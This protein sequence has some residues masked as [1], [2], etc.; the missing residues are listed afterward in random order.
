MRDRDGAAA[1]D[2]VL[3]GGVVHTFAG[4]GPAS[5][6]AVRGGRIVTVGGDAEVGDLV[7]ADTEVVDLAGRCVLPGIN[8]AHLHGLWLG[9]LWPDTL[10]GGGGLDR[11][12]PLV[13]TAEQR[14]AA[15]G[16]AGEICAALGIT[17]YTEPGL[18]PGED[19]GATG[20]FG[21]SALADYVALADGGRLRQRV[22]ALRLFGK[23]DGPSAC[24]DLL[25]GIATP[26][27]R[28]ADPRRFRVAGV[29]IFADGIPPMHSAWLHEPYCGGG[30]GGL[31]VEGRDDAERE[32]NL[33]AMIGAA[34]RA[35]LQVGVHVTGDRA[36]DVVVDAL[37]SSGRVAGRHYL[38][39]GDLVAPETLRRMSAAG[40]GLT[41]QP[42]IA[43]V[44][45]DMMRSAVGPRVTEA[46]PLRAMLDAG[47]PLTIS[48][49]A[50]VVDPDWRRQL[51]AAGELLGVTGVDGHLVHRL[52]AGYTREPA[53]L[54]RAEG[55]KGT[56]AAGC[57]ADLCVLGAD[58]LRMPL[59]ELPDVPVVATL[60]G[61]RLTHGAL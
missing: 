34:A 26:S 27:P 41:V 52:L 4:G 22:T 33:R 3:R 15:I 12:G 39:H 36:I 20:C 47:V 59:A 5:A 19:H 48:S 58:P 21:Q 29:K 11:T 28:A 60:L 32:R 24:A 2:L 31:L 43:R 25:A 57:V 54:D 38:I 16:R 1:A 35:G 44:T 8:D 53:V 23:L 9:A 46:W 49:D 42:A 56:V 7:G 51:A 45:A 55:W 37:V 14:R 30:Y 50:P 40:I 18:G 10:F 13:T 17:S 6:L 61:G